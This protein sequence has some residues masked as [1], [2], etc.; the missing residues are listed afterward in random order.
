MREGEIK[1]IRKFINWITYPRIFFKQ[2]TD[3]DTPK[4]KKLIAW[5]KQKL[6]SELGQDRTIIDE[7]ETRRLYSRDLAEVPPLIEKL[8]F[9]T[10][11]LL[12]VQP[13][14][15][16]EVVKIINFAARHRIPIFPRG[17]SSWGFGGAIPTTS[18]L[19]IDFSPMD[20]IGKIDKE[21]MTIEVEPG[22]KWGVID[23]FLEPEG[24]SLVVYPS[25]RFSTVGGWLSTGGFGLNSSKYGHIRNWIETI[26]VATLGNG[27]FSIHSNEDHFPFLFGAEGH[28][29]LIT[30]VRLR[31]IKRTK[32]SFPHLLYFKDSHTAFSFVEFLI[33]KNCLPAH[34]KF[35]DSVLMRQINRAWQKRSGNSK[36]TILEE[37]NALLLYFD[38]YSEEEIFDKLK[39]KFAEFIEAPDYMANYLWAERYSPLKVQILG[40]SLLASEIVLPV[41]KVSQ[42]IDHA[43]K[44][45]KRYKVDLLIEVHVIKEQEKYNALVMSMFNCD[46]R[47]IIQYI[48]YLSLGPVLTRLGIK[49]G[50]WPYG[51]GIWNVPFF[52]SKFPLD[53]AKQILELKKKYDPQNILNPG[54]FT[55][56][57][58]RFFNLPAKIFQPLFYNL[59]IDSLLFLSPI[60]GRLL[61]PL[62]ATLSRKK[63]SLLE[64]CSLECTNCGNCLTV[65]PSYLITA[66]EGVAPRSKLRLA[67]KFIN[68]RSISKEESDRAFLCT[69]CG[70][71]Q[72]VC[73]TELPLLEAWKELELVLQA[74]YGRPEEKIRAFINSLS[75]NP[76]YLN[77]IGSEPY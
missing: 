33:E 63:V 36:D 2:L 26:E 22:A 4:R 38:N 11:P 47:K 40:P 48:A 20:K 76:T 60:I 24:L 27:I 8:L 21:K 45:G 14:N 34:L 46:R 51:I 42:F 59:S 19:V 29:G 56:V 15:A 31:L 75:N 5:L 37:K 72:D 69:Q 12:V 67:R 57:K 58:T 41:N 74:K 18:G 9:K 49:K 65:C 1:H 16:Q 44:I 7:Y 43:K 77:L 30:K 70:T 64:F 25:N 6:T 39:R 10:T 50:G 53:K 13:K 32:E 62:G 66:H 3:Q 52:A 17:I 35:M 55:S 54:K 68:G 71:C 23:Q 73:Q 61:K 28:L